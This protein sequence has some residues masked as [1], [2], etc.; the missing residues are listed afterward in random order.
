ML[1]VYSDDLTA[2]QWE[3]IAENNT[4]VKLT[5]EK[6]GVTWISGSGV[7]E[8]TGLP[9]GRYHLRESQGENIITDNYGNIYS[10]YASDIVF[11]VDNTKT[12][13]VTVETATRDR[14][15]S[16]MEKEYAVYDGDVLTICD[17]VRVVFAKAT[18]GSREGGGSGGS[19]SGGGSN[20]GGD[21]AS[22]SD[23]GSNGNSGD[24]ASSD[25]GSEGGNGDSASSDGGS[26][27]GE[28]A[29]S[30]GEASSAAESKS[31][32][33]G[34]TDENVPTGNAEIPSIAILALAAL[35]VVIRK[36]SRD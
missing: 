13:A 34:T 36:K 20:G 5:G 1:T 27:G 10:V 32:E 23:G 6:N 18:E 22:P 30:E 4:A 16:S 9:N 3:K 12:P 24:T 17:A 35:T 2:E 21:T 15:N 8:L 7:V 19:S 28:A 25:G 11:T 31:D 14:F 33:G 26:E 29:S